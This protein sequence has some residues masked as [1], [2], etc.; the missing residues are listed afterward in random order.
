MKK[1]SDIPAHTLVK[2]ILCLCLSAS[3]LGLAAQTVVPQWEE[4]LEEL[5]EEGGD[6]SA[7]EDELEDLSHRLHEPLNLNTATRA[8]LE[9]FPFLTA[10]QV[11]NILAYI[12]IHGPMQSLSELQLVE[13]MDRRT[14]RLLQPFL[15]VKPVEEGD[16]NFPSLKHILKYGRHEVLARVDVPFY[17]RQGY[18][19]AYLGP[20]FYHSLRYSFR[21][22]DYV[23]AGFA[24]EKDAGEPFFA[25]HDRRGYDHYS[26]YFLLQNGG[27]LKTLAVGTYRLDFGQGL[28]LGNGFGVG[29][30]F[31][32]A[33]SDYRNRGIRKHGSTDEYNYFRGAAVTVQ[34]ARRLEASAFYSHREMDGK[35]E[36]GCITSIYKTGLHRT[37]AEA[38][39]R[40]TFTLQL[41][42]GNLS[43]RGRS[44]QAGLTGIYYFFDR[45]YVP[46]LREYARYNLQGN[47][48][49]NVGL[50][51]RYRVGRFGW[52]G[53]A[54][55]GKRGYA[56]FNRL[57][58]DFSPDYRLLLIHRYYAH[59]YWAMFAHAFGEGSTPQNE[60]GWYLAAE[61]A[62]LARWR[63]FVSADLFSFP[64]W[65]Y[66]ISKPSQGTDLRF[67]ATY[68]PRSDWCLYVNYRFK[69]RERDVTGTGGEV[70]LPTWH[71]RARFR[72]THTPGAFTL[73]TTADYTVFRQQGYAPSRGWQ[74]T[75]LCS[76]ALPGFPLSISLQGTYFDT[77]DY[78][79]RVYVYEKGL[80]YSFYSPSFSGNGFRCSAHLRLDIGKTLMLL[81]KLGHTVYRDRDEIGSGNDLIRSNRKTDL[82][83]QLR[84]TF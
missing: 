75:Q 12:Y 42:G 52:T 18:E 5:V 81:A 40:H 2:V 73:Q 9:Q 67:Q 80:L 60:N 82:Q 20:P 11:E 63:F 57:S 30:S 32:L 22:G 24:A 53:E 34:A 49:Y 45:P 23:Q 41:A 35:V 48:F 61:V 27:W 6:A 31:S 37:Q 36:D 13:E 71:H 29:K 8:Q 62:P 58:Y 68:T 50:D 55:L 59:D 46:N 14:I 78:D 74:C 47:R 26:Y 17:T 64:W 70:T 21:R 65:R 16:K 79:S 83:M 56:F 84:L 54:A 1:T 3:F 38:D 72:L 25:L 10:R 76:Y 66:R 44:L 69:R 15:C 77:D 28:V 19:D 7:W 33:T 43:Y 39:K 4:T 51:Y